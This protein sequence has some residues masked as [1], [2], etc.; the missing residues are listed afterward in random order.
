MIAGTAI[1]IIG[2]GI[3]T[4]I[5]ADTSTVK[6]ASYMVINCMGIGMAMQLPY[7]SLQAVLEYVSTV[8]WQVFILTFRKTGRYRHWKRYLEKLLYQLRT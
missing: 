1:T 2:A 4:T 5:G 7:A 6:W 3:L 8:L